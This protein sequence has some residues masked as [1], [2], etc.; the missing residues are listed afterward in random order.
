MRSYPPPPNGFFSAFELDSAE[1]LGR[2]SRIR[3][4]VSTKYQRRSVA[5]QLIG[6][7]AGPYGTTIDGKLKYAVEARH[8]SRGRA[9]G[10]S[11]G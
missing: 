9:G 1:G 2:L 4:L 6:L 10:R 3:S 11:G 7:V 5:E 8:W